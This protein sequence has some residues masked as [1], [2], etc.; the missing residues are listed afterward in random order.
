MYLPKFKQ[1]AGGKVNG[2]LIDPSTGLIYTG[3]YVRDYKGNYFKGSK[4]TSNSEPLSFRSEEYSQETK[5]VNKPIYPTSKEIDKG[6]MQRYFAKDKRSGKVIEIDKQ[7]YVAKEKEGKLYIDTLKTEWF[8][9]QEPDAVNGY[10][11]VN[12]NEDILENIEKEMPGVALIA[13]NNTDRFINLSE[14]DSRIIQENLSANEGVFVI[15]G[16]NIPYSGPY[17]IHPILG[18]MAGSDHTKNFHK[19][20]EY[21]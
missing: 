1:K 7:D 6:K 18:P 4:I 20:L 15:K 12:K 14:L 10:K 16:T 11:S 19:K 2:D 8:L 5:F 17:H 9:E 3:R 13:Q 21:I